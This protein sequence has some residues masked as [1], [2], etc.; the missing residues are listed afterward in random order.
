MCSPMEYHD[1]VPSLPGN[2]KSQAHFRVPECDGQPTVLVKPSPI[3][4]MV[5]VKRQICQKWFNPLVD[6]I[7]T[8]LNHKFLL[9][10]SPVPEQHAWDIDALNIN[11]SGLTA[12]ASSLPCA[13]EFLKKVP[14]CLPAVLQLRGYGQNFQLEEGG[15]RSISLRGSPSVLKGL[16]QC[17]TSIF[18]G[19][20]SDACGLPR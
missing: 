20:W 14:P 11:W 9:Y 17:Y 10:A 13:R 19:H 12:Y 16:D 15:S 3:D 5:T 6:L 8:Y 2:S 1:L 18:L 7:A 4:R